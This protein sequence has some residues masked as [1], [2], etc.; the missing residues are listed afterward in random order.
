M[1]QKPAGIRVDTSARR[2]SIRWSD[3]HESV[4][5][6]TF[7]RDACPCAEC[8]GGHENMG[9]LPDAEVYQRPEEESP[10]TQLQD[11][12]PVGGYAINLAWGDGH[13]FGIYNWDYL[14][15]ICPCEACRGGG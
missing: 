10:R 14:R 2:L 11:V 3:G 6:F 13:N 9:V 8:R 5:S 12:Q 7:L 1:E 4:Y 15:A